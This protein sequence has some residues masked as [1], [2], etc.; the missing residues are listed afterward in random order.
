MANMKGGNVGKY[1]NGGS[2]DNYIADGYIKTVEKVWMDSATMSTTALGSDDTVAIAIIPP[3]KKITS[4]QVEMPALQAASSTCTVFVGSGT[5]ILMTNANC[6]LGHLVPSGNVPGAA[7][8]D[9]GTAT[10]LFLQPG[11]LGTVTRTGSNTYLYLKTVISGG[12][13]AGLTGGTIR[14]IVKYT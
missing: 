10:T 1:D 4:I 3:N 9:C 2:G 5:T 6:Y 7:T 12:V 11:K 14:S 13:D 8:F